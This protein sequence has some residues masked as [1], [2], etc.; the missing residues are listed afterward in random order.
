[1]EQ[2]CLELGVTEKTLIKSLEE[3]KKRGLLDERL[4]QWAHGLRAVGNVGAHAGSE[5]VSA[6]DAQDVVEF[7]RALID[8]VFTYQQRF[9]AFQARHSQASATPSDANASGD[10]ARAG[11]KVDA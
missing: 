2:V 5:D 6:Q 7:A 4:V 1:M 10:D 9:A 3:L 8:Y 11:S